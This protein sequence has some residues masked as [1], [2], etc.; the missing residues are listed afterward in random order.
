MRDLS[1][2]EVNIYLEPCE[3]VTKRINL[4]QA[5]QYYHRFPTN[6]KSTASKSAIG[7]DVNDNLVAA[8]TDNRSLQILDVKKLVEV[9]EG[10]KRLE[11]NA[12]C[13]RFVDEERSGCS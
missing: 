9:D 3:D 1:V 13:V 12:A 2:P 5:T 4:D 6:R 10:T 7:F 8:A 11:K